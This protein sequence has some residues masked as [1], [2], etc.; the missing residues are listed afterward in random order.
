MI[1]VSIAKSKYIIYINAY[2]L[3]SNKMICLFVD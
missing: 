1:K 2:K 3:I